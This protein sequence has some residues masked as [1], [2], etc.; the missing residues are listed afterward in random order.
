MYQRSALNPLQI[1]YGCKIGVLIKLLIVGADESLFL[2]PT[3]DIIV[4]CCVMFGCC[5]LET[6]DEK[7]RGREFDG[8]GR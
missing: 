1:G 7:Q 5:L 8:A 6:C 2:F 3:R 4:Y